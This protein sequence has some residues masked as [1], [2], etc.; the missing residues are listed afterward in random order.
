V[1]KEAT[2]ALLIVLSFPVCKVVCNEFVIQAIPILTMLL[3][4]L[5]IKIIV[6]LKL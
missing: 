4:L 6:F 1:V 3:K 2:E 5:N